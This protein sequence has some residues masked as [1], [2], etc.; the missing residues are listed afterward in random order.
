LKVKDGVI[1][2]D[3]AQQFTDLM[4]AAHSQ[5]I[6]NLQNRVKEL[7][8]FR[9]MIAVTP[10]DV[11]RN[12]ANF[13][14][15]GDDET[16]PEEEIFYEDSLV[17]DPY[18]QTLINDKRELQ[19]EGYIIRIT[20]KG[21]FA[22]LPTMRTNFE[23]AYATLQFDNA[24]SARFTNDNSNTQVE[25][26]E[27]MPNIFLVWKGAV[28]NS[29][30]PTMRPGGCNG[31]VL[32]GNLFGQ[33]SDCDDRIDNRRRIRY[34]TYS[35]NLGFYSSIGFKTRRQTRFAR[36]WWAANAQ[37][38]TCIGD[39]VYESKFPT[40]ILQDYIY[41]RAGFPIIIQNN[42]S[43]AERVLAWNTG[44]A[45][46]IFP[47]NGN[48]NSPKPTFKFAQKYKYKTHTSDHTARHNNINYSK[49]MIHN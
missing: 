30:S 41:T 46:V 13:L 48:P 35:Q 6:E 10:S 21:V 40:N 34:T 19:I 39:G 4:K 3:N 42:R 5:P 9:S 37:Q 14:A 29:V 31:T 7:S 36:I 2:F 33:I 38:L 24:I 25:L 43:K 17:Q 28:E 44:Q 23:T 11:A 32:G 12:G 22:Y 15:R 26:Q 27:V 8:N 1:A 18:V 16:P 47:I 45:G 49:R 20:E